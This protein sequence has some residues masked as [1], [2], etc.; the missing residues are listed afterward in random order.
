M[1]FS[2]SLVFIVF[3]SGI[4]LR[5]DAQ[6]LPNVQQGS[7]RAPISLKIDGKP[8]EWNSTFQ[9][10]NRATDVFYSI[11]NDGTNLYLVIQAVEPS[12]INK[13]IGGGI[14]L[15]VQKSG[16]KTDA[17]GIS[18]TYPVFDKKNRPYIHSS[19]VVGNSI[20][21]VSGGDVT[22]MPRNPADGSRGAK[23]ADPKEF[24]GDSIMAIYNKRLENNSKYI[25]VSGIKGLDSLISVYNTDG[26]K[27]AELFNSKIVYTYELAANLKQLGLSAAYSSKFSY[28]I[29]INGSSPFDLPSKPINNDGNIS[30]VK[31]TGNESGPGNFM[32]ALGQQFGTTDFWGE[33]T[34]TKN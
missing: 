16:K 21:T 4:G 1:K 19:Q 32:M 8:T 26:I 2:V 30:V 11:S 17:G 15:T 7:L 14:T 22:L 20:L 31:T 9:A 23:I 18:I 24:Q 3:V 10:Y 29:K 27:V 6:K 33:Y 12:V 5:A 25:G 34:L 13:I 28:H